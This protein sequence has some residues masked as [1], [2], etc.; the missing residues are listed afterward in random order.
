MHWQLP[1]SYQKPQCRISR[2]QLLAFEWRRLNQ[3]AHSEIGSSSY[4]LLRGACLVK[5]LAMQLTISR[6]EVHTSCS[7]GESILDL[8][9]FSGVLDPM[10]TV[11][12]VDS[13]V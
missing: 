2:L 7:L 4:G 6:N 1:E 12:A 5:W 13:A 3:A 9:S 11:F 10:P 8:F